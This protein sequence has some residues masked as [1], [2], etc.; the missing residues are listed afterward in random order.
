MIV[1][2]LVDWYRSR[3]TGCIPQGEDERDYEYV[4]T[5]ANKLPLKI[6]LRGYFTNPRSQGNSQSCAG[7]ATSALMEYMLNKEHDFNRR[8]SSLY[9]WHNAKKRHGWEKENKGVWLRNSLKALF[10]DGFVMEE[11]FPF[12]SNYLKQPPFDRLTIMSD[13]SK[14]YLQGTC[15]YT[16]G[17]YSVKDSLSK[18]RPVI[19]GLWINNSFYGNK[20][21]IIKDVKKNRYAHAMVVVG[22]DDGRECFIVRNSWG[23]RWG[24]GG[25]CYIPYNYFYEHSFD[26]WTIDYKED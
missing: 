18:G 11:N 10:N 13:V 1:S 3:R 25:Y 23:V 16:M 4:L 24:D 14:F 21:G 6:D 7:F 15:Y 22:Y 9:L 8:V 12:D 2:W 19:F 17:A 5:G 20:D 26:H